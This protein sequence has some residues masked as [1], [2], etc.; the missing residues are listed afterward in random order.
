MLMTNILDRFSENAQI[1]DFV[2]IRLVG[3]VF[4]LTADGQTDR[5]NEGNSCSFS[6]FCQ[7]HLINK[8][9]VFFLVFVLS[10]LPLNL[11]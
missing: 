9:N 4:F 3:D 2:K 8:V 1:S 10:H 6:Q 7:K 11:Q 5:R